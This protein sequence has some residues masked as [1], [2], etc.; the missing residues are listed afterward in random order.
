MEKTIT[1]RAK[2]RIAIALVAALA[3]SVIAYAFPVGAFA[4]DEPVTLIANHDAWKYD[5]TNT[6]LFGD[7]ATDF[8]N[9]SFDDSAWKSG[10]SPLGYPASDASPAFGPVSGG[11]LMTKGGS[12]AYITYYLRKDFVADD[13]AAISSLTAKVAVDDGFVMYLNGQEIARLNMPAGPS[14][15]ATEAPGVWEPTEDRANVTLDLTAYAQYLVEGANTISVDVHNRDANSSDIYWGMSLDAVYGDAAPPTDVNKT[16]RQVN[17]HM[18]DDPSD[19]VNV[20]YT[21]VASDGTNIVLERA[22]G[23]GSKLEFEGEASRGSSQQGD[24]YIHKIAVDGL[25]P[26][27]DYNYLVGDDVLFEGTFK[28]APEKGSDDPIRFIYLADTQVSNATNAKALGATLD[29]VAN[30]DP[31]FV[32]LAGDITDTATSESQWEQLFYNTGK[33]KTGGETMFRNYLIS[34]IQGNH[35]NNTLNRHINAPTLESGGVSNPVVYSYDYGPLTF[36]GLNLETARS[37]ATARAEQEKFLR[38]AVADAKA[39]GQWTAVGFHKS[40]VTGASHIVDSDVVDARKFWCPKFAE[41][42]V[43]MVLQGHDHVYSRG[44]VDADGFKADRTVNRDGSINKPAG[45]PLYMIGGHAGGL[46]WYARINYNVSAGDPIAPGYS[47]LDVDSA[48]PAHN[49]DNRPSDVKQEQVIVQ[50]DVTED[51]VEV[52]AY[53]FKYD[54]TK[55]EITTSKYLYDSMTMTRKAPPSVSAEIAGPGT[56]VTDAG[57]EIT[58]TVSYDDADA[59]AFDTEIGYDSDVLEFVEAQSISPEGT[60]V[61]LNDVK[62]GDDKVRV[63]SGLSAAASGKFDV[64]FTFKAIK[65][66][67]ADDTTVT[68]VRANTASGADGKEK[69]A[70]IKTGTAKTVFYKYSKASDIDGDG[71]VTLVDLA[72]ALDKYQ[73][74]DPADRSYD[75]DLSGVV[76]ALDFLIISS[77]IE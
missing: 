45:A 76:D 20:T 62:P 27:T 1:L 37:N 11:T 49:Q 75:I 31:D 77:F 65:P 69:A 32:Y 41:L 23:K 33:Y 8:W 46:K 66:V 25:E 58:Y 56:V 6:D 47:F 59:N 48:N 52:N 26:D 28:T 61:L 9:V 13:I 55:D 60:T 40:L 74:A 2:K 17:V 3:I 67:T 16:P 4:A 42:D 64:K 5:D 10:P 68:L 53:M 12:Q 7:V 29:E 38:A 72:L 18:G 22:D 35:D 15:H 51:E 57:E 19:A 70:D 14:D 50:M 63:T 21:T 43:D 34:A 44:F 24:K 39:R 30:M 73:S 71:K 54:T 36:I